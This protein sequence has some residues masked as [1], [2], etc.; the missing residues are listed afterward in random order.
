MKIEKE[1]LPFVIR[2]GR[3]TDGELGSFKKE[4]QN[5]R[6]VLLYPDL[7]EFAIASFEHR[8]VYAVLNSHPNITVE[9]AYLPAPDGQ[10]V[11]KEKGVLL[12]T[13]E[14]GRPIRDFDL[15][16]FETERKRD[17]FFF[18]RLAELAG[19]AP[20]REGRSG[21]PVVAT[22]GKGSLWSGGLG[23]FFDA[24]IH[25]E[26]FTAAVAL[27]RNLSNPDG[28]FDRQKFLENLEGTTIYATGKSKKTHPEITLVEYR[29]YFPKL[30]IPTLDPESSFLNIRLDGL[31]GDLDV[32]AVA[33][34]LQKL[35]AASGY[36]DV[37]FD[38]AGGEPPV[39]LETFAAALAGY[40]NKIHGKL[41]FS[42]L[43][44]ELFTPE[45]LAILRKISVLGVG[46]YLGSGV[47]RNRKLLGVGAAEAEIFEKLREVLTLSPKQVRLY[48]YLG[49]PEET[50]EEIAETAQFLN[51]I[52]SEVRRGSGRTMLRGY[53]GVFSGAAHQGLWKGALIG[54][55]EVARRQEL[56]KKHLSARNLQLR[57][58]PP[59][60]ILLNGLWERLGE[61]A[62]D[63]ISGYAS[64]I[65][66]EEA[67]DDGA[68][69]RRLDYVLQ[70]LGIKTEEILGS[71]FP[72]PDDWAYRIPVVK[73]AGVPVASAPETAAVVP[74]LAPS[75][76]EVQYG[77][78]KRRIRFHPEALQIP[79]TVIR[80]RWEKGEEARFSSHLD[81]IK[82][83]ERA[84][85][86]AGLPMAYSQGFRPHMKVA[87]GP[88]LPLG[89][90]STAEYLDLRF[91][92]PYRQEFFPRLAEAL[93]PGFKL[94]DA[95]PILAKTESLSASV[96]VARY[97][98]RLPGS[99]EASRCLQFLEQKEV[100]A[101]RSS[102]GERR[103]VNVRPFVRVLEANGAGL[104]MELVMAG[105]DFAR[106]EEV[107]VGM[108]LPEMLTVE[109]VFIRRELLI[110]VDGQL[111]SPNEVS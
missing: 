96:N 107:L 43:Q 15:I 55:A 97:E 62:G 6:A 102:E 19:F 104:K 87:F 33:M 31:T 13:V 35:V 93:P 75:G 58:E 8:Q 49:F 89:H 82:V 86:R 38:F 14:S 61:K 48:L 68:D 16:L 56:L 40:L 92:L 5:I 1:F 21:G 74:I 23:R 46:F 60:Q 4:G 73:K 110:F 85:R 3:Y 26:S 50:D 100:W 76:T 41:D 70:E 65:R 51:R 54:P 71:E 69:Y 32:T 90:L 81:V 52:A 83:F 72:N 103:R 29:S 44:P 9:R 27:L 106:P 84:L 101:E 18:P 2:P 22:F 25:L 7:Y 10:K 34:D 12:F 57:Y 88:P 42:N 11:M 80:F 17:H 59:E 45:L 99:V 37:R 109:A 78:S 98:V 28:K 24:A 77:R 64:R 39:P 91:E 20:E 94:I 67:P 108:G 47:E 53:L 111:F 95:K 66:P 63:L 79:N 105:G 30:L 36:D